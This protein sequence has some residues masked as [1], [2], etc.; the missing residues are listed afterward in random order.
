MS[1]CSVSGRS[2][3]AQ[4]VQPT[5]E[6]PA[7]DVS[8][9]PLSPAVAAA[10]FTYELPE[11]TMHVVRIN[12]QVASISVAIADELQTLDA[13][14]RQQ[15]AIIAINAGFFDPQNGKTTSYLFSE[16]QLAG[17]PANNE[18]LM[19]NPDLQSYLPSILNRSEF[20]HYR[21]GD[22]AESDTAES[23]AAESDTYEIARR[24][25]DIPAN[26]RLKNAVGGGPQLLPIDTSTAE[27]FVDYDNG[28]LIRDAIGSMQPNARSAV[29]IHG[30]TDE[31]IFI[32]AA[33]RA[34]APGVT[35]A[36][37][38]EF[39]ETLGVASLLNLDGGSSSTLFYSDRTYTAR[40]DADGL[41]IERPVKSVILVK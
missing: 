29:G 20:R 3:P 2:L 32:M 38:T 11:A 10:H 4:P 25:D 7:A 17:E 16:G 34:D 26:C 1:A 30:S 37:L 14:A 24:E 21:C 39:A 36:E 12:P 23:D 9:H 18:R 27:A 40:L 13:I 22:T 41:P 5:K 15:E 33:Q 35:L 28:V 19:D 6:V 31:I 8:T